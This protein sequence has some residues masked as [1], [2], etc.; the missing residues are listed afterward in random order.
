MTEGR[1]H[2]PGT[3]TGDVSQFD[4][5]TPGDI[6]GWLCSGTFLVPAS[7]FPNSAVAV[8]TDQLYSLVG[9]QRL[10]GAPLDKGS[11]ATTGTEGN[12]LAVRTVTGGAGPFAGYIGEQRQQ[13]LGFNKSSGVSLRV[14]FTLRKVT[15]N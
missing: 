6:G 15:K 1:I 7:A 9:D 13:F 3:I 4:P 12:G 14:T 10:I 11:I 2:L 8:L 5:N